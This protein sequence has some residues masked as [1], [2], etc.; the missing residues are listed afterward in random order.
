PAL[1]PSR[2]HLGERLFEIV[3]PDEGRVGLV[4]RAGAVALDRV[5]PLRDLPLELRLGQAR[6][7]RQGHLDAVPRR[8]EVAEV[9]EPR[10]RRHPL[11]GERS[12]AR[13]AGDMAA[14]ALVEDA[15][16]DD[17]AVLGRPVALLRL[18]QSDLVPRVVL[19]HRVAERVL[20][21]EGLLALPAVEERAAEEDA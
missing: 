20:G 6:G 12:A 8:L 10:L 5:A 21:D 11:A 18:G 9:D 13:V 3:E 15:R 19:V 4:V 16:R 1:G 2:A 14:R 17:P 7:A